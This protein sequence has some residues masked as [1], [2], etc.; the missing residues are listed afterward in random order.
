MYLVPELSI[1]LEQGARLGPICRRDITDELHAV[2]LVAQYKSVKH[3]TARVPG[4]RIPAALRQDAH[5]GPL[6]AG[7]QSA[8]VL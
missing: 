8:I 6:L 5:L 4:A 1:A 2:R 3:S 7:H